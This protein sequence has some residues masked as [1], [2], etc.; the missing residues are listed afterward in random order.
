MQETL[1]ILQH[2]N[3]IDSSVA[4]H[5]CD[6]VSKNKLTTHTL[7][8]QQCNETGEMESRSLFIP[9]HVKCQMLEPE[10]KRLKRVISRKDIETSGYRQICYCCKKM[11]CVRSRQ[12]TKT[13]ATD[14]DS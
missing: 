7:E 11:C 1:Y 6:H 3:D 10:I 13:E 8:I 9:S 4:A 12:N 14:T 5:R 2:I